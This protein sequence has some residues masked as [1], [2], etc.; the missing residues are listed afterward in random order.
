MHIADISEVIYRNCRLATNAG[1]CSF[2]TSNKLKINS[3]VVKKIMQCLSAWS[4][5]IW[6]IDNVGD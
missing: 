3:I 4:I 2:W 6:K 5:L 1:R